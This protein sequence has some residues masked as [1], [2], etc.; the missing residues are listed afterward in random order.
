MEQK[1]FKIKWEF[2]IT[3]M[4]SV[5]GVYI[6]YKANEMSRLQ[7]EIA[8][9]NSLPN[10]VIENKTEEDED[11]GEIVDTVIEITNL[12]GRLNNYSSDV[13]TF[14]QCQYIDKDNN[15]Y[16]ADIPVQNY[17]IVNV[18]NGTGVGVIEEKK[19]MSNYSEMEVL[20]NNIR[21]YMQKHDDESMYFS[22]NSYLKVSYTDLLNE[23][24]ILYYKVNSEKV[25]LLNES[26]GGEKFELYKEQL[27][28]GIGIDFNKKQN[29]SCEMLI[30]KIIEFSSMSYI[31]N[32][33]EMNG[34]EGNK[35]M[36]DVIETLISVLVGA[37]V[38]YL[39]GMYQQSKQ[40]K[41][42]LAHAASIL[43]YDLLS[44]EDYLIKEKNC[45]NLRYTEDWQEIVAHCICLTHQ[46]VEHIY[47][48]YDKTYNYNYY[49]RKMESENGVILKTNN[50]Y[51]DEIE[52]LFFDASKSYI[53]I[54]KHN[55]EYE[56]ILATLEKQALN[57][58]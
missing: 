50:P 18:R 58:R 54:Q 49:Y 27:K 31:D 2:V 34:R 46:Q 30:D 57:I 43:Y 33:A 23:K 1:K 38:T 52:K 56:E 35:R 37:G 5:F 55:T 39:L 19:T 7:A 36:Q 42:G 20:K 3:M 8:K 15:Y 22:L 48:I 9:N 45:V 24:E 6:S 25:D 51:Y 17:Y 53:N 4:I 11:T 32:K 10:F 41:K 29:I 21:N 26:V 14:L 13:I 28:A 44:I 40:D 16:E 47:K 12:E